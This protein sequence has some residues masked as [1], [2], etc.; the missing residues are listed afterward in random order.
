MAA[1]EIHPFVNA[2]LNGT[3]AVL[4]YLGFRAIRAGQ[5]D[6]HRTLMISAFATSSVFLASYLLRFA[7][8]GT[9]MYPGHGVD[10]VAYFVILVSHMILA[11][12]TV[13]MVLRALYLGHTQ[14]YAEH[15][16]LT[17]W[18]WPIWMYV[19]VTGVVVYVM[20]YHVGPALHP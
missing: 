3:S 16:R 17:R 12:A 10:R 18:A 2:C 6:R 5:R 8:T 13:P 15:K 7:I 20:L 19:S 9:H 14:R 1:F 4:L 11:V